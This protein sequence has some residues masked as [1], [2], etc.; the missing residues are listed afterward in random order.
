MS[1]VVRIGLLIRGT[2]KNSEGDVFHGHHLHQIPIWTGLRIAFF[3]S[4]CGYNSG[5]IWEQIC[6]NSMQGAQRVVW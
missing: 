2:K 5:T 1:E 3:A 4:Y 6:Y